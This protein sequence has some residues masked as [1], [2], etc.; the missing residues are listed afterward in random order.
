MWLTNFNL[1]KNI[2]ETKIN[3][4]ITLIVQQLFVCMNILRQLKFLKYLK[5]FFCVLLAIE[6]FIT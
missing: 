5:Y 6:L 4:N 1:E 2:S 3:A